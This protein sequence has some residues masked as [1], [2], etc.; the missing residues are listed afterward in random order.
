MFTTAKDREELQ[1]LLED[2]L[3]ST[4]VYFQPPASVRM[5][6]PAI[7]YSLENI[8]DL[9]ANN[10]PY[11]RDKSYQLTLIDKDPDNEIVDKL[12]DLQFCS[13]E[14]FFTSDNLNHFVYRIFY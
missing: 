1:Y 10:D 13:F 9:P 14:R 6:Y 2:I 7:V 12:S 11:H 3:G 5:K 8:N 4:N